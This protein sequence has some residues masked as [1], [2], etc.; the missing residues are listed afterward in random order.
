[1]IAKRINRRSG[2]RFGR[3]ARYLAAAGNTGEKLDRLWLAGCNAGPDGENINVE[4][5]EIAIAEIEASQAL[6]IAHFSIRCYAVNFLTNIDKN[7]GGEGNRCQQAKNLS[8]YNHFITLLC[9][10]GTI[11]GTKQV[12]NYGCSKVKR[13]LNSEPHPIS[14][15]EI[16]NF[17]KR[18][19]CQFV[20]VYFD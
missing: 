19:K 4:D 18:I 8:K 14:I 20:V 16:S 10:L 1:M 9:I 2:D 7:G 12:V 5:L 13:N 11:L 3:L 17:K 6:N 15:S